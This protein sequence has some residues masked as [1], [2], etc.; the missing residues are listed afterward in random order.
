[1]KTIIVSNLT[2]NKAKKI[3]DNIKNYLNTN[4]DLFVIDTLINK[5]KNYLLYK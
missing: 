5:N 1:M 2:S 3:I 4:K